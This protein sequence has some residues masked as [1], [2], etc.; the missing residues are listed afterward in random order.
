MYH[1]LLLAGQSTSETPDL[2]KKDVSPWYCQQR[3]SFSYNTNCRQLLQDTRIQLDEPLEVKAY[4]YCLLIQP[5]TASISFPPISSKELSEKRTPKRDCQESDKYQRSPR[6]AESIV[7]LTPF[8]SCHQDIPQ[9]QDTGNLYIVLEILL[10]SHSTSSSPIE[11]KKVAIWKKKHYRS[12]IRD[13]WK[14]CPAERFSHCPQSLPFVTAA[15]VKGDL[16][17]ENGI[18]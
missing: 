7:V 15:C 1:N 2:G 14:G 16:A 9:R 12:E 17:R 18:E 13:G 4:V 3:T 6:D 11:P 5:L 8:L 10:C